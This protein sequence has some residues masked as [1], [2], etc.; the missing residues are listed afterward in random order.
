MSRL[1]ELYDISIAKYG[2][3]ISPRMP[4]RYRLARALQRMYM[5]T[6]NRDISMEHCI[7]LTELLNHSLTNRRVAC[8]ED[9]SRVR[10]MPH[11]IHITRLK[12]YPDGGTSIVSYYKP[13]IPAHVLQSDTGVRIE[14]EDI[15]ELPF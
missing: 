13:S 14:N 12:A 2:Y 4:L 6:R 8:L 5:D 10:N 15:S 1:Q 3:R 7:L 9:P 11:M